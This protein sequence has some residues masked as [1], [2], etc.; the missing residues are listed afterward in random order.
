MATRR[1][2]TNKSLSHKKNSPSSNEHSSGNSKSVASFKKKSLSKLKIKEKTRNINKKLSS[3]YTDSDGSMPDMH[4]FRHGKRHRLKRFLIFACGLLLIFS[5]AAWAG[6]F[7][8]GSSGPSFEEELV[9]INISAPEKVVPGESITYHIRIVNKQPLQLAQ[10]ELTLHYPAGFTITETSL[11]P[12]DDKQN[13]WAFGTIDGNEDALLEVSGKIIGGFTTQQSLRAFLT[14]KPS[15]FNSD[16]QSVETFT[17]TFDSAPLSISMDIPDDVIPGD[18]IPFS[19]LVK[20]ITQDKLGPLEVEIVPN[21]NFTF[22]E[23]LDKDDQPENVTQPETNVWII[24]KIEPESEIIIT[25]TGTFTTDSQSKEKL[26]ALVSIIEDGKRYLQSESEKEINVQEN[27]LTLSLIAN[28]SS[29]ELLITPGS[30]ITFSLFYKNTGQQTIENL[31]LKSIF[32]VPVSGGTTVL[33][34]D[35]LEAGEDPKTSTDTINADSKRI[36]LNWDKNALKTQEE[37]S[38]PFSMRLASTDDIDYKKLSQFTIT[39]HAEGQFENGTQ[40]SVQTQPLSITIGSDALLKVSAEQLNPSTLEPTTEETDTYKINWNLKNSLHDL[41]N[42]SINSNLAGEI[43][44]L[45]DDIDTGNLIYDK[46]K[47]TVKWSITSLGTNKDESQ[48]S[49]IIKVQKAPGQTTL[50]SQAT[51]EATDTTIN[52]TLLR[53]A[54]AISMP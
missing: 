4:H 11:V 43:T 29:S 14:Y 12:S 26:K 28:G 20:N 39:A 19:L 1:S 51:L 10:T 5:I 3:I 49:F 48:A 38:I 50:M 21:K 41:K 24:E 8:F 17:H 46:N 45:G 31:T 47:K 15:N 32:A 34:L 30:T 44:W 52:Q 18:D 33:D 2:F 25:H 53:S 22:A 27:S 36:T 9:K 16:F 13:N 40:V 42:V 6:F 23:A 7:I 35:S 37:N 54:P